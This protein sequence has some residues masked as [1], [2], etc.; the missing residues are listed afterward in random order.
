[1]DR[2]EKENELALLVRDKWGDNAV[3]FLVGTLSSV[4]TDSQLDRLVN[5]LSSTRLVLQ[6]PV[7]LE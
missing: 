6:V 4:I 7:N 1:M 5:H 3:E 2:P